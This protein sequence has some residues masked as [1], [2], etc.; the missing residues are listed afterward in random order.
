MTYVAT[1]S[2]GDWKATCDV[3]GSIV[4]ASQ[5]RKRWDGFLVDDRCWE[6]RHPQDF[7]RGVADVQAPLF[8][9]DEPSDTFI[10]VCTPNKATA[11]V[12]FA[13]P[14]CCVVEYISPIF[15]PSI[16]P[17]SCTTL[18]FTTV[19]TITDTEWTCGSLSVSTDL[20][21]LGT[22]GID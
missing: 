12:E 5:L 20:T 11:I 10:P 7:V 1:Y 8:T 14:G 2:K 16:D 17:P 13:S 9:R 15:D 3:C 21:L 4:K 6:T 22:V 18:S 19:S